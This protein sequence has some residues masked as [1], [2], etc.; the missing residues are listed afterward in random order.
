MYSKYRD[1][2]LAIADEYVKTK[3]KGTLKKKMKALY[4]EIG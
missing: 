4:K 3:D 1:K 2:I